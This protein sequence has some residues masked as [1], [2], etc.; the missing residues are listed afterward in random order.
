M[1]PPS[2]RSTGT[3]RKAQLG[4]FAGYLAA[5]VGA[6]FGAILLIVSLLYPETLAGLRSMAGDLAAPAGDGGAASRNGGRNFFESIAGYYRA[7]SK[8][9]ELERENQIARVKLAEARAL[10]QENARL[11][12]L[13]GL[14]E[15]A[16]KPVAMGRLIGSTTS[17]TRRL[18]YLSVGRSDGV[19]PGMPVSSPM[20]LVGRVVESGASS[21]RVLLL[22]DAESIIPVRRATDDVVALAEGRSDGTIRLRLIN[23][24]INPIKEGDVFVTSGAGGLFKPGTAVAVAMQITKDG[25][26]AQLVSNPAATDYVLVEAPW[27]PEA[28]QPDTAPLPREAEAQD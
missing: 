2:G 11:K 24:G 4:L 14:Y 3:N 22:T 27:Q 6:L 10:E 1:A 16:D 25:A 13:I 28:L 26:I 9:A 5:T 15:A 18:A 8:N 23:L 17:S 12:A 7:G 19:R 20:G 21:S